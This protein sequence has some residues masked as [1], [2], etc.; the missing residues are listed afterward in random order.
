M[1]TVSAGRFNKGKRY[2]I[3]KGMDFLHV[4]FRPVEQW[5]NALVTLPDSI[6]FDLLRSVLGNIQSPFNK[7]RLL[8]E[9]EGFLSRPDIQKTIAGYIDGNDH[10]VIAAIAVLDEPYSGELETFFC[11][12]F[13]F[14]EL[15][16]LVINLEERLIVYRIKEDGRQRLSLNPIL[17]KIL[18]PYTGAYDVLFPSLPFPMR[19]QKPPPFTYDDSF[20]AALITFAACG[21]GKDLFK[22]DGAIRKNILQKA[23]KIFST[24]EIPVYLNAF[25]QLGLL[26]GGEK[27][28]DFASLN[29]EERFIYCAAAYYMNQNA[30]NGMI[31]IQKNLLQQTAAVFYAVLHEM[32]EDRCYPETT[33]RRISEIKRL[34][35]AK[36]IKT[37]RANNQTIRFDLMLEA[38]EKTGLLINTDGLWRKQ[39]VKEP[40][41]TRDQPDTIPLIAFDSAFSFVLLPEITLKDAMALP[42]FC[43]IMGSGPDFH[44]TLTRDSIVRGFNK[45]WTAETTG[46][47]LKTLSAGRI[48]ANLQEILIDWEKRYSE[49]VIMDGISLVLSAE[50]RFLAQMEPLA[51][52][53]VCNP[54]PGVYLLDVYD[55]EEASAMLKK[56]GADIISEPNKSAERNKLTEKKAAGRTGKAQFVS[57]SQKL[58]LKSGKKAGER[59]YADLAVSGE[60]NVQAYKNHFQ[61]ILNDMRFDAREK[62]ELAARI[63]RK[64]IL[65][66][67]QLDGSI[68]RYEKREAHGLDFAGKIA[69]AKQAIASNELL[70]IVMQD[71]K[72]QRTILGSPAAMEKSG[73]ETLLSICPSQTE[74]IKI[75]MGK[76]RILRRIKQSIFSG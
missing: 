53:I 67:K 48:D 55:R 14:A 43:E 24:L 29:V 70:E 22:S 39:P 73:G 31:I 68:I 52:H 62:E 33:L 35:I 50:R 58:K 18:L 1:S 71:T 19:L 51:S 25:H 5:K 13:S 44:F 8:D 28:Q 54:S 4:V 10:R 12:E 65:T 7:Q 66:G 40:I 32:D 72:G 6:F 42:D 3:L 36:S 15:N 46:A 2:T 23:K 63:E 59:K 38:L 34:E 45:G 64:L 30:G 20:F 69:L 49:I 21:S 11:G 61:S 16:S 75:P 57:I 26:N 47:V 76:I 74:S 27:L 9:L 60:N 17:K 56:A 37:A 41:K